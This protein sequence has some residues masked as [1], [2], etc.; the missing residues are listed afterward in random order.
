MKKNLFIFTNSYPYDGEKEIT[1]IE[2]ELSLLSS[3]F[4]VTIIPLRKKGR[5]LK[6]KFGTSIDFGFS[7]YAS[8]K[9]RLLLQAP[10]LIISKFFWSSIFSNPKKFLA[11]Q[12]FRKLVEDSLKRLLLL[13]WLDNKIRMGQI[14]D[15]SIFYTYWFGYATSALIDI[16]DKHNFSKVVTRSH[17]Y[18]LYEERHGGY[19]PFRDEAIERIDAIHLISKHGLNYLINKYPLHVKKFHL[20]PLGIAE[21]NFSVEPS[22][23][24]VVRFLSC[25]Y[26]NPVKRVGLIGDVL[27]KISQTT[28]SKVLWTHIGDGP[29]FKIIK[30]KYIDIKNKN[31]EFS[32][33]GNL[34]P[35]EVFLYY[36]NNPIDFFVILSSY[37]G[38]PVAIMEALNFGIPI[39]ASNVGGV[40]DIVLDNFNGLLF[41]EDE[42]V[43][44]M[45][46]KIV[47]LMSNKLK[48][49]QMRNN[50]KEIWLAEC[51]MTKNYL[52]FA[53]S[54]NK[55]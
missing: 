4:N 50:S 42:S 24:G 1:F 15:R 11:F 5:L 7:D 34:S 54:L 44:F 41:E 23:D 39:I 16:K 46:S 43:D 35:D 26:L 47:E 6:E 10:N 53:D 31:I 55:I 17:N 12:N 8:S 19:I 29:D 20:S 40:S 27:L 14:G 38:R 13:K 30:N 9:I 2:P 28:N 32:F 52:N 33:K 36:K 22:S 18:D 37:E 48:L 51:S 45:A 21:S 3:C 49:R 25:S